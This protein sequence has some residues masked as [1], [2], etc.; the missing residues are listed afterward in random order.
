[1]DKNYF[2]LADQYIGV[3]PEDIDMNLW[4]NLLESMARLLNSPAVGIIRTSK[5]GFKNVAMSVS[6]D[7]N[8][9]PGLL[10]PYESNVF[11]KHVYENDETLYVQDASQER[12][13]EDNPEVTKCG[14]VS[15][16]GIPIHAPNGNVY[17]TLCAL[18]TKP[19]EYSE[20]YFKFMDSIRAIVEKELTC[21]SLIHQCHFLS[22][23]DELTSLFNRRGFYSRV[24]YLLSITRRYEQSSALVYF[25][26]DNLKTVNDQYGHDKGDELIASFS[27]ALAQQCRAEDVIGRLGGDEF[28]LYCRNI[29][30]ENLEQLLVRIQSAFFEFANVHDFNQV[31]FS[32]GALYFSQQP[33]SLENLIIEADELMYQEKMRKKAK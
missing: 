22:E 17:A 2:E 25:D 28:I 16:L 33:D 1:M 20:D 24:E 30:Q 14:F 13:W 32:H 8:C 27:K 10:I 19:T 26:L 11:C 4:K 9:T 5:E 3:L 29:N 23:H 18:D 6:E 21:L 12:R 31:G 7:I 15:Y